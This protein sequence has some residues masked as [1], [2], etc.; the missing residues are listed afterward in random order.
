MLINNYIIIPGLKPGSYP[1]KAGLWIYD[2][3]VCRSPWK[4]RSL[5]AL[6]PGGCTKHGPCTGPVKR[7][8]TF[9]HRLIGPSLFPPCNALTCFGLGAMRTDRYGVCGSYVPIIEASFGLGDKPEPLQAS[10]FPETLAYDTLKKA[11]ASVT[12]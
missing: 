10:F 5:P 4:E 8:A 3:R 9:G 1:A 11:S 12:T 2:L 7:M 6:R